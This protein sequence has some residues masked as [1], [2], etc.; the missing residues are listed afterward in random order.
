MRLSDKEIHKSIEEGELVI[1]G[2]ISKYP[3]DR[4][5]QVQP[6]SIDLRLDN[7]FFKFKEDIREFD[8]KNLDNV[9]DYI[10][11]FEVKDGEK[12]TLQP[13]EILFGQ[14]Y[15][16][17]RI[18]SDCS[19]MIEGR[20]RFARL[21]LSV[22]ATG[23][24]IN[25]EFEG[26]MPLQIINNNNIPITIY[27]FINICQLILVQL[28]SKPLIA[29]P[30]RSNNP[31]HK[32]K[33]ASPSIIYKDPA[34]GYIEDDLP[35]INVEIERR[36]IKKYLRDM[37]YNELQHKLIENSKP[38]VTNIEYNIENSNIGLLNSGDIKKVKKIE[39]NI[40]QLNS[41]GNIKI[42]DSINKITN[43]VIKSPIL[44]DDL[45]NEVIEQLLEIS[46]Q[47]N[48]PKEKRSSKSVIRAIFNSIGAT[49]GAVG[50]LAEIWST[51]G[52][53]IAAFFGLN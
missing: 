12:I 37:E 6:C 50:G 45:K 41:T 14:I 40:N 25:P 20:S 46:K 48:L 21:G 24:F 29:Y 22:H 1:V 44:S 2:T 9:K 23:G 8:I 43:E 47:A 28:T 3:F 26:A 34:L 39:S 33:I 31:Y 11:L 30:K 49:L 17:L 10:S 51:W 27:P 4:V 18:P 53:N 38:H 13:H 42:A 5:K 15:E 7:K 19:G 35:N 32:E 36:L 16:Q 52:K